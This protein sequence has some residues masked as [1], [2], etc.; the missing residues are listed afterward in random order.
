MQHEL[1]IG[2]FVV[3]DAENPERTVGQVVAADEVGLDVVGVQDHPYQ[4]RFFDTWTLLSYAAG[5]TQGVR[6]VPDVVN[7]PLRLPAVLAKSAASLD[8]LSG[9]RF[10]L[11]LG[12]G[13]FWDAIAA[14]GGER[15]SP[16]DA[17][18]ALDEAI[19]L[20]RDLWDTGQRGGVFRDGRFY[21]VHGAKRGPAPAHPIPIWVGA[22]GPRMLALIGRSADGWLPSLGRLESLDALSTGNSIIDEAATAAGRDPSAIRRL[23]NVPAD[24]AQPDVLAGLAL[25]FWVST[26]ILATDDA[27]T[28][29]RFGREVAPA[30]REL[31]AAGR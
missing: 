13:A 28:I 12:A 9:G 17:V 21:P 4:R 3:P 24:I 14:M 5:R 1:R 19:G 7:L 11:A 31:V 20:I 8:L 18:R 26:F 23:L 25:Q 30:T 22:L 27:A 16:G 2:V 15:R 29:E 10:T 6:L